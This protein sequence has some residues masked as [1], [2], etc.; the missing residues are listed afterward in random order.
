MI[1]LEL[2]NF[3][4]FV[5]LAFGLGGATIAAIVSNKAEKDRDVAIA[6]MKLMPSISKLIVLGLIFL[7]ISG[8]AIPFFMTWPLNRG[9]LIIKHILVIFIV[10]FGMFLGNSSKKINHFV[11]RHNEKP[12][13]EFL[14]IKRRIKIF[15]TINLILWYLTTILSEFI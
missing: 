11:P 12:S 15:S 10:I 1:W 7:I 8:I 4:H 5:G 13:Q 2:F 14:K 3:I 9:M 6:S